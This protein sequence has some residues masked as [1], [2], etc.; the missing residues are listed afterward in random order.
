MPGGSPVDRRRHEPAPDARASEP[1]GRPA[2]MAPAIDAWSRGAICNQGIEPFGVMDGDHAGKGKTP[3]GN[4]GSRPQAAACQGLIDSQADQG[5]E[6]DVS[7]DHPVG[8]GLAQQ[9]GRQASAP[10]DPP[11]AH[12]IEQASAVA[13][14]TGA[15]PLR[16]AAS[17]GVLR[18]C[19]LAE[20]QKWRAD[21]P[22][23]RSRPGRPHRRRR[24]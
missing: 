21:R 17:M 19:Q 9:T 15:A 24:S 22:P 1:S 11:E 14:N 12:Q 2:G 3:G 13:G 8:L 18:A 23:T 20:R 6:R 7:G 16:I 4:A 5:H 10:D